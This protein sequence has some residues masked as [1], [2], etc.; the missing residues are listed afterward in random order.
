MSVAHSV[1]SLT[2]TPTRTHYGAAIKVNTVTVASGAASGS[3]TLPE[4]GS[5]TLSVVVTAQDG[6]TTKTY[7][8]VVTRAASSIATLASLVPSTGTLS[9]AFSAGTLGYE[10]EIARSLPTVTLASGTTQAAATV[11]LSGSTATGTASST[12]TIGNGITVVI[13]VTAQDGVTTSQYTVTI[14]RPVDLSASLDALAL[15][16]G[17]LSPSFNQQTT[18]YSVSYANGVSSVTVT[19]TMV[20][21]A[22][23][24]TVNGASTSSA[25][26]ASIALTEGGTT[27]ITMAITS[28]SATTLY[29]INVVRAGS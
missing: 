22:T 11:T 9:P 12:I 5:A 21:S 28:S 6:T 18:A 23:G 2:M 10:I 3:L 25:S 27:T 29:V 13:L 15:S 16:Q 7:S 26:G 8:V 17:T 20:A 19:P 24:M 14:T 1:A 4:G